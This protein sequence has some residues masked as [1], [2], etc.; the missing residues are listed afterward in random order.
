M[1]PDRPLVTILFV[2][3]PAGGGWAEAPAAPAAGSTRLGVRGTQFTLNGKPEFLLGISYYGALGAPEDLVRRDLDDLQRRRF[4]WVRVWATWAAFGGDVSAVDEGGGPRQPFLSRLQW[5]TAECDRRGM[6]VDVTLS[7]GNGATGPARLRT[8][9]A[10]RRAVETLAAA[11]K[12]RRNAYVDLANERN[13]RDQRFVS[14]AELKELRDAVKRI[15]PER[16]ITASHGSDL[17]REELRGYVL[18]A[19]VDFVCPHRPRGPKSPGETGAKAREYLAW[20][21]EAGRVVPVHFQEPFRRGYAQWKPRARDFVTDLCGARAG[22]AA[23]WCLHNGGERGRPDEQPRRSFDLREKRLLEQLDTEELAAL[24]SISSRAEVWPGAGWDLATP[25][26]QGLS[27]SGLDA[28]KDHATAHGGGSG[29][30]IRHGYIVKEWGQRVEGFLKLVLNA[31][32]SPPYPPSRVIRSI[33]WAPADSIVRQAP[34]SDNWPLTWGDDDA[35]Y[36][37]YGDGQGFDPGAPEKLSLGLAKVTGPPEAFSGE[38]IRSPTGEDRGDGESGKKAS[39]ILMVD[40][41]LYLWARNAGN[42][43]LAWSADRGSTWTWSD[44]RFTESF[45]CPTFLNFGKNYAGARDEFVYVYSHDAAGAYAPAD[46]MVLARVSKTAIRQRDAY[47]Y[48]RA[49]APG[50]TPA[51][52]KDIAERGAVFTHPGRC[53]RSS[54]SY[55]AAL[56]RYLWCQTLPGGDPRFEGG[57]GIYDAPEPWGPW[58]TAYFTERWDVGPGE[59]S[60]FPAKWMSADGKT[61]HLVFSLDDAFS[62]RR[63]VVS[64]WENP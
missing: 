8:L 23:G 1:K 51:W 48:F 30:I 44:W 42:S 63:G 38:N 13:V 50:G 53:Y 6:I 45:G 36:T 49:L 28:V 14:L 43:R 58:T 34:G 55:D 41:V 19:Q 12:P 4:N 10:H 57:F 25:E 60:S 33:A 59:T 9:E 18:E 32:T 16:L 62:V 29:C 52:T 64:L 37:A 22:G 31:V 2:L 21:R 11:L 3:L 20:M 40:G 15:D 56:K 27:D 24:A 26:S 39:G 47:E 7:R 54:V 5:L 61:L 17:T 46:R 35:L